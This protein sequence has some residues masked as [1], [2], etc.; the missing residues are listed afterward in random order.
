[1]DR[2]IRNSA[3][4]LIIIDGKLLASKMN[5]DNDIFYIMPGGGQD[6]NELLPDAVKRECA[7]EMGIIVEPKSLL[8]VIE[9]LYGEQFHRVDFVFLCEY[10][11]ELPDANRKLDK[12]QVGYEWL[13][14][15]NLMNEPLYPARL[16]SQI[17]DFYHGGKAE[18]YLGN[19]SMGLIT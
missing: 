17:I 1:M 10:L 3:K 15:I 18:V 14:I 4:T 7:E 2:R 6:A 5:E 13:P 9:G 8:F 11:G 19:E 16:R 12:N